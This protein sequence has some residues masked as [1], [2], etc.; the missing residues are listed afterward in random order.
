MHPTL[1]MYVAARLTARYW[2][3]NSSLFPFPI[4]HYSQLF[5]TIITICSIRYSCYNFKKQHNIFLN[6][7]TCHL[8]FKL[9]STELN[10]YIHVSLHTS[11]V[12]H[13]AGAYPGFPSMHEATRNISTPPW[14]G[15]QSIAGLPPALNSPV[16]IYTPGWRETP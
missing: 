7:C 11:Q 3:P 9:Q 4:C 12:A 15:C 6:T 10:N 8:Q 14:M 16:P 2:V 5:A 1:Y 13:Q